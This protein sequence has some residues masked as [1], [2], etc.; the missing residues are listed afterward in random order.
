MTSS[1]KDL[2]WG[3]WPEEAVVPQEPLDEETREHLDL[4]RTLRV[5]PGRG[6]VQHPVFDPSLAH[7]AKAMRASEPHFDDPGAAASWYG[8]RHRA[9]DHVLAAVAAS[10]WADHL[11]LRGSVVLKAW[12]GE[13]AREPGDLDFVVVPASWAL[14]DPRTGRMLDGIARGAEE[15]SRSDGSP[16]RIHA[17]GADSE[18]IW[19]YDR[20]P[21]RRLVLPWRTA[22]GRREGTVQLDFVFN[23][24][25]PAGPVRTR[26]PSLSGAG[27]PVEL[28]TASPELSLA[29]KILWLF[30]DT[31]PQAKDLYD[32]VLLAESAPP[33]TYGLLA[34]TFLASDPH[35]VRDPLLPSWTE[36]LEVDWEEFPKD[37][38]WAPGTAQEYV[39]R[40]A[41][42]LA[43][44]FADDDGAERSEY[45]LRSAWL[46]PVV[47]WY[48]EAP[49]AS[50]PEAVLKA[51]DEAYVRGVD[52][53]VV[54]R[55]LLGPG[56]C[57]VE[58]A[59]RIVG[60]YLTGSGSYWTN[61]TA[62]DVARLA[63]E[64]RRREP[65]PARAPERTGADPDPAR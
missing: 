43:P 16:V 54:L 7:R 5:V 42:A 24:Q 13:A 45:D 2:G 11:V 22:D 28:P 50:D 29:W 53:V 49:A 14:E 47:D 6:V 18:K 31:H 44:V 34:R 39:D 59:G 20:V 63:A 60:A 1:W 61:R 58:R 51:L 30:T 4:P 19:T 12:F 3:P 15:L 37:Y 9:V 10:Q 55:E 41:A 38:R 17:D 33:L 35:S 23:E 64:A 27:D 26:I 40:L 48:R 57:T 25:L 21:G 8:A 32:A 62:E 36:H 65:G 46:A 52:M 56:E